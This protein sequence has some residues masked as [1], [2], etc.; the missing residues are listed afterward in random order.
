MSGFTAPDAGALATVNGDL[1]TIINELSTTEA[2][3]QE[4]DYLMDQANYQVLA[5]PA[6]APSDWAAKAVPV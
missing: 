5:L 3:L 1:H 4:L 6:T 2:E